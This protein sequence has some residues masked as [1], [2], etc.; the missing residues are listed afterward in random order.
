MDGL[1]CEVDDGKATTVRAWRSTP[2]PCVMSCSNPLIANVPATPSHLPG[3]CL[4]LEIRRHIGPIM[5]NGILGAEF[6]PADGDS[7]K[8]E[9]HHQRT[10]PDVGDWPLVASIE[11]VRVG[12]LKPWAEAALASAI[13]QAGVGTPPAGTLAFRHA[14][15]GEVGG[16]ECIFELLAGMLTQ[17]FTNRPLEISPEWLLRAASTR[18]RIT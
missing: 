9:M 16:S 4:A 6:T 2:T 3:L 10:G 8:V 11:S 12:L 18:R 17:F 14:A 13:E 1:L 5:L 7:F 15:C